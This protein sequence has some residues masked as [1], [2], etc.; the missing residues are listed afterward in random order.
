MDKEQIVFHLKEQYEI[1]KQ[2]ILLVTNEVAKLRRDAAAKE[3]TA[4]SY[5]GIM[6]FCEGFL[7]RI[8]EDDAKEELENI[9]EKD[10]EPEP[11]LLNELVEKIINKARDNEASDD[12]LAEWKK[13]T[14]EERYSPSN[15]LINPDETDPLLGEN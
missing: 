4:H 6:R 9:E 13:K 5:S 2:N 15:R 8:E 1:A 7:K 11:V 12:H 14:L 10:K 3:A